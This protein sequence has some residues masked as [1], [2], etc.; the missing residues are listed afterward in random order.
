MSQHLV[1]KQYQRHWSEFKE[2]LLTHVGSVL[3]YSDIRKHNNV[4]L[5]NPRR[6]GSTSWSPCLPRDRRVSTWCPLYH[7]D[8]NVLRKPNHRLHPDLSGYQRLVYPLSGPPPDAR[9]AGTLFLC[10]H[11]GNRG[12][13]KNCHPDNSQIN[14]VY[15]YFMGVTSKFAATRVAYY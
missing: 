10:L 4:G 12:N 8:G 3:E 5:W 9:G 7:S 13:K 1:I 2:M 15:D 14:H 6:R 11:K